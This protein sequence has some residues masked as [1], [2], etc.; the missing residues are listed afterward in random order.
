MRQCNGHRP[1]VSPLVLPTPVP[2]G[3][4]VPTM[5]TLA[6]AAEQLRV[7][8]P[9]LRKMGIPMLKLNRVVRIRATDFDKWITEHMIIKKQGGQ[10]SHL[11]RR[12]RSLQKKRTVADG[13]T[14]E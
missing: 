11:P 6:Q 5:M 13:R 3:P 9:T 12:R 4:G 14:R 8:L 2:S 1:T 10:A 7:S